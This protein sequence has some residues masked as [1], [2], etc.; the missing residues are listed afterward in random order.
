M[1]TRMKNGLE[2]MGIIKNATQRLPLLPQSDEIVATLRE[3]LKGAD[4]LK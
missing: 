2:M 3:A 4:L 1:H